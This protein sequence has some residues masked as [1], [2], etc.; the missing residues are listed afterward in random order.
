MNKN[1]ENMTFIFVSYSTKQKCQNLNFIKIIGFVR[2]E[3]QNLI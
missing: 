1:I 2:I 3:D